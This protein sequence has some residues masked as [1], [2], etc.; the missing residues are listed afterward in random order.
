MQKDLQQEGLQTEVEGASQ[1]RE[2]YME[3]TLTLNQGGKL[4]NL[5]KET[6]KK[7]VSVLGVS[8]ERWR[9]QGEIR[10]DYYTF[11]VPEVEGLK[12]W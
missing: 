8:E 12:E 4:D 5:E 10:N 7:A 9:G 11:Y 3:C 1:L 6:Q 2:C